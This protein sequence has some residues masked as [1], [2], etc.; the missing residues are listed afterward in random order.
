MWDVTIDVGID[1]M[2]LHPSI[3]NVDNILRLLIEG[4][5]DPEKFV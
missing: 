3:Y 4:G 1:P 2:K 5:N